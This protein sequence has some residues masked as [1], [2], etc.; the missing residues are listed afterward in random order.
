MLEMR[1]IGLPSLPFVGGEAQ[2]TKWMNTRSASDGLRF[3]TLWPQPAELNSPNAMKRAQFPQTAAKAELAVV[4]EALPRRQVT[5][6]SQR[7]LLP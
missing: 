1:K 5:S 7:A 2:L 3:H 6:T 4:A